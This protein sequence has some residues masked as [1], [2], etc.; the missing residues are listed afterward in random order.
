MADSTAAIP[1][2][3]FGK[4][5]A[6]VSCVGFGG[7]HVGDA[8]D[9]KEAVKLIHQAVDAGIT[10][11]DNCWEYH[12]GKTEDWMGQ[13]L[14]GRREKVFL[15][16]KVC[17]HGRDADLAMRMLEQSLNRLQTDHLDLWQIHGVSFDNDP[18][19]F[20][21]PNG[22]AE[23]LRKAKEQGKVRFV[24]FTGHKDPDIHLAMLNTGF[25]FDAVQMPLNPFDYHFR[26]FQ[27]KVLP[28]LQK[29]GIAALGM[30]PISGHG[31]AVKRGVLSG[32]ESLRYAMS[33]P[34][35]TTTITGIDKQEALDQAIK[36]ARGFQ[37]MTEQEMSALRDRVKPYAGDGRY[38]L[39]KVSLKFDNPE[40][41]MAHDFPLDMQSVEVKEMMKA[42]ENTGK[43]FPEAK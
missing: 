8:T 33:L 17:T 4:A 16:S 14:K 12:R 24:G 30:K 15:M 31:D 26:S 3:K 10:F 23:A 27:G 43:P 5:D 20:I 29:R 1:Q 32:E 35:V 13:G 41:R 19:L 42:T 36:V 7:H 2:R 38:E 25:P 11:F 21:R 18:E 9:V 22:A 39:Y 37:P 6:T 28:E 34:G 40:A